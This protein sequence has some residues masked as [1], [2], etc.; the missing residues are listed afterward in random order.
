MAN[1][2]L[3]KWMI[4]RANRLPKWAPNAMRWTLA[5]GLFYG[6]IVAV[7]LAFASR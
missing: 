6:A 2:A 4:R 1:V 5:A 7:I 3:S